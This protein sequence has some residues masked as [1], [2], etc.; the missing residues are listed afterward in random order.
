M[1]LKRILVFVFLLT[2]SLFALAQDQRRDI[3]ANPENLQ[4]L[5]EDISSDELKATMRG[6]ALGLGA[7]C[8]NCHVGEAGAPLDTFDFASDEKAMKKKARQMLTMVGDIN[9]TY[10][11][12]LSEIEKSDHVAVRCVTCH[13]GRP[14][15][16]LIQDVLDEE[17]AENGLDATVA[18]YAEL[19]D[20]FFGSHSY[21]FSENVLP[22]YAQELAK[23]D[24]AGD[25]LALI[26]I[27]AVNYPESYFTFFVKGELHNSLGESDGALQAY[28]RALE[29]NPRAQRFLEA[30]ITELEK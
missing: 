5:P 18:K 13:R 30:K 21:D 9:D 28:K 12:K 24:Q 2:S 7:R 23:R 3:F 11:P 29:L 8:E 22:M 1:L 4:V 27:N 26:N 20:G 19:R 15:P 17:L 10:V 6:F 14:Q 25:A 16:K